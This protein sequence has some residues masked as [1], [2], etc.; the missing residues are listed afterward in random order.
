MLVRSF[1]DHPIARI[2]DSVQLIAVR[3]TS[4]GRSPGTHPASLGLMAGVRTHTDLDAWK[5]AAEVRRAVRQIIAAPAF[6]REPELRWQ[7]RR[8]ANGPCPNIAEGFARFYPKDF[9]RFV[10][11]ALGS[12][13]ETIDHLEAAVEA[14]LVTRAEIEAASALARRAMGACKK[15][16]TYL[17][18]AK[19]PRPSNATDHLNRPEPGPPNKN[20][21]PEP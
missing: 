13:A 17:D 10:R 5:L 9:A 12:L 7:L 6:D 16:A 14:G 4:P 15:L 8:S 1:C 2:A 20:S 21:E 18:S 19:P 11:I 3:S